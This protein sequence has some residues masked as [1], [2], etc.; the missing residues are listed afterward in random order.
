MHGHKSV[1]FPHGTQILLT[2]VFFPTEGA[3]PLPIDS[4]SSTSFCV[5][6]TTPCR[7][8]HSELCKA[9]LIMCYGLFT[10]M[11][12]SHC[13]AGTRRCHLESTAHLRI[14]FQHKEV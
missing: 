13:A 7:G 5:G 11:G 14:L 12:Q 9:Q 1:S 10:N 8:L 6:N 2:T 3:F 4:S